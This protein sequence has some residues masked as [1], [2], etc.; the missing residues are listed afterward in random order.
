M[1]PKFS[2]LSDFRFQTYQ[3]LDLVGKDPG[4]NAESLKSYK[5]L[6]AYKLYFDGHV[7]DLR[8][9]PPQ[10]NTSSYSYFVFSVKPTERSKTD[11]RSATYK[12][13]FLF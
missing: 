6:L 3:T 10:P 2:N 5:S 4:Y 1:D 8:Y 11:D 13:F 12:G 7:E 9:H